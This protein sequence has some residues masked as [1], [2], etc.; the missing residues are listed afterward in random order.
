M[1]RCGSKRRLKV[2]RD[3]GVFVCEAW[4]RSPGRDREA[5]RGEQAGQAEVLR[6]RG[7]LERA[8]DE[9]RAQ[10]LQLERL[11]LLQSELGDSRRERQVSG[12]VGEAFGSV[13]VGVEG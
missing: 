6:L 8:Q 2:G 4:Q 5:E 7:Q 3:D 9:L 10:E 13:C 12:T 1:G 11:G